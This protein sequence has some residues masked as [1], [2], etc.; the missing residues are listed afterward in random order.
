[1]KIH[2]LS[3]FKLPENFRGRNVF[4]V[5]FWW[6]VQA[7]F[8]R[9]SPQFAYGYRRWLLKRF[10]ASV[11][12]AVLL[13]PSVTV[14][15]PWKVSIG[16]YAWIGDNVCLYSLA[17]ISI[18]PHAVISQNSYICGGDHDPRDASFAIRGRAISIGAGAWVAA[19][20][21]IAP[22]VSIGDGAVIGARSSVF[23]DMP[24]GMFCC[25][26]PCKVIKRRVIAE[27]PRQCE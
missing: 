11:G 10:G 4:M 1:M 25:G 22:G 18:G 8:F 16:D 26:T 13:R 17:N 3:S 14:T 21:F 19:D 23:K 24:E 27:S 15:Y 12:D 2:D 5:Q 7:T 6:I 20:V 9:W